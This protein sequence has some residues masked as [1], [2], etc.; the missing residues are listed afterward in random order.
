MRATLELRIEKVSKTECQGLK[1]KQNSAAN[2]EE[3]VL[4]QGE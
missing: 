2:K 1:R 3:Q 4:N